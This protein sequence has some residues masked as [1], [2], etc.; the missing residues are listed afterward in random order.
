MVRRTYVIGA[1]LICALTV[2]SWGASAQDMPR[3]GDFRIPFTGINPAPAKPMMIGANRT[4]SAGISIMTAVN[5]TGGKLLHNMAGRCTSAP[6][7]DNDA[8]TV[9]NQ[10]Y[11]DYVDADGDH[12]FERWQYPTQPQGASLRGTGEWIGGTGKFAGLS[13]KME[14]RNQ[15]VN[16]LVEGAA[17]FTGEKIGSYSFES[18]TASIK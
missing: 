11:C 6:I 1:A 16:S 14:I 17:Q 12:V 5:Q 9:E 8:K 3:Q 10:G 4:T 2:T 15:R 7:L 18:K 13:G